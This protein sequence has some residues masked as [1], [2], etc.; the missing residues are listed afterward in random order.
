MAI[1]PFDRIRLAILDQRFTL[2]EHAHDEMDD[3]SLDVLNV[4]SAVLTG[5]L[6]QTLDA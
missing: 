3:D 5:R 6:D 1:G 4:E 2:T